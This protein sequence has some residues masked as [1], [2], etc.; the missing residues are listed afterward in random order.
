VVK[1]LVIYRK[2]KFVLHCNSKQCPYKVKKNFKKGTIFYKK[3]IITV[4]KIVRLWCSKVSVVQISSLLDIHRNSVSKV[5]KKLKVKLEMGFYEHFDKIGG[6]G[7]VVEVDESKFGKAKY[8]KG[9]RVDGVWVF[10]LVERAAKRKILLIEVDNRKKNFGI[11]F[12]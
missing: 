7:V 4:L 10:G 8:H 11:N 6:P 12:I 5:I 9:H 2:D 3:S 1:K